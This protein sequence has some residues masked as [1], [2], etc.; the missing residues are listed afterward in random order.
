MRWTVLL[1]CVVVFVAIGGRDAIA[2]PP[3]VIVVLV[4]DMG[5][6]DLSCQGSM[7]YETPNIDR[8]AAGGLRFTN[9]YAACTVCSP[10]RA[11]MMTG[12]YPARLH[13]TDWI[14]GHDRPFA[15]LRIP[16]W[17]KFLPLETVTVAERLRSAGYATASIGKWHLG[18]EMYYPEHQGFD[19]N[20]GGFE[21]GQ[22]PSYF[23]PYRIPTLPEGPDREYLT[24][25]EAAEAVNF[26]TA[27][28]ERPFL[29]YLPHYCVHTPI[30]AKQDVT[31]KYAAKAVPGLRVK[32]DPYAAMVESVDD[33]M[34][35]MLDTLERLGIRD[36]TAIFFTSDNGGL[37][38]VTD[39]FP[40]RAGKGSAYEGGVRV[41]FIVSWPGATTAG[42]TSDVP[43]ITPDIPAT[44]LAMTEAGRDPAQPMDGENL[45][46]LF[47]GGRLDRDAIY[48]HYP[49]YHPGGATPYS[50]IRSGDWRLVHFH[51][52]GRSELYNLAD[53]VGER[54]DRAAADPHRV[55]ELRKRLD[56]WLAQVG[57]QFP[58]PNPD[59][60]PIRDVAKPNSR[61][62][63]KAPLNGA[64]GAG[65]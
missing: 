30:Q 10:S 38:N 19:R 53:D 59:H 55:A 31:A 50:A 21:R 44:I 3:N 42:S 27:N 24:D 7:F 20:V 33:C 60:D 12:Q 51:E 18:R 6:R 8:L 5:W 63:A 25:R 26:I 16:D 61:V 43:V 34:G 37:A 9:G 15:K 14:P 35:R 11:A 40:L 28:R 52:E 54:N 58:S 41:P 49:H 46:P 47:A 48:W 62:K 32:N 56:A 57:G 22:P 4:D 36:R 65:G 29:L 64:N 17:Q 13:I 1:C 2:V 45:A 39:N 23:A